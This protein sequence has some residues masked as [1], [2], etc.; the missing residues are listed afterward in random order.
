MTQITPPTRSDDSKFSWSRSGHFLTPDTRAR[1]ST[2]L[3]A[4]YVSRVSIPPN[5]SVADWDQVDTGSVADLQLR[6][7]CTVIV[8][9][10]NRKVL[11]APELCAPPFANTHDDLH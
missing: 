3:R 8:G 5:G 1:A 9:H 7:C 4:R 2:F 10:H 6:V 11:R